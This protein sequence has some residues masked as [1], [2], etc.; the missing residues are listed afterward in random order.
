MFSFLHENV[1]KDSALSILNSVSF[2]LF[3]DLSPL[4]CTCTHECV[5]FVDF[6]RA[7]AYLCMHVFECVCELL[8]VVAGNENSSYL[9]V[10]DL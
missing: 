7:S 8:L 4:L 10:V 6:A 2:I 1:I 3:A 5:A 9:K